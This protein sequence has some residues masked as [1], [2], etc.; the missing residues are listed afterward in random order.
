MKKRIAILICVLCLGLVAAQDKPKVGLVLSGG[1][2]KGFAHIGALKIIEEAGVEVDYVAGTSMGAIVGALYASGYSA[3]AIDSIFTTINFDQLIADELPRSAKTF[4][5][6]EDS[7]RYALSLPFDQ[8]RMSLPSAISKGQNVYNLLVQLLHHVNNV[9]DFNHLPIPFFCIATD[10]ETGKAVKYDK[11][12]LPLVIAASGAFPSLFDPVEIDGKL[13]IDGGVVDNYPVES[14]RQLG[15]EIVIG[16][17][18]QDGLAKREELKTATS[19]L[20][21]INNFR[22]VRAME[23][24]SKLTDIYIQPKVQR[25]SVIDFEEGRT[26]IDYGEKAALRQWKALEDLAKKTAKPKRKKKN[27]VAQNLKIDRLILEGNKNYTRSYIRGKLRFKL[28]D[29]LSFGK[30]QQGISNLIS[31][32]N[33]KTIRYRLQE[34]LGETVLYLDLK[35]NPS[36]TSLR[37]AAHYDNLYKTGVLLNITHKKLLTKDDVFSADFVI[38]DNIRTNIAYY[39]DKGAYWSVGLNSRYTNFSNNVRT[40]LLGNSFQLGNIQVGQLTLDVSDFTNQFY[41]ETVFREEFMLGAGIEHKYL[42]Y[43]TETIQDNNGNKILFEDSNYGSL[44]GFLRLDTYDNKYYPRE[45]VY[46]DGNMHWFF[47]STNFTGDFEPFAV[48]K[49]KIGIAFPLSSHLSW[50]L[51]TQGGFT[52]QGGDL[53]TLDFIMGG[54]GNIKINNEVGFVGYDFMAFSGDSYVQASS[55]LD[56]RFWKRNHLF[57]IANIANIG[58][59]IFED[60]TW[61]GEIRHKGFGVGYGLETFIGPVDILYAWSPDAKENHLYIS[62]GFRF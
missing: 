40:S 22:T 43:A 50:R 47:G 53:G 57:A 29:S 7:E 31:T 28:K 45:G 2:A 51:S 49:A 27:T 6:K 26:I 59:D 41:L 30:F 9:R 19:V 12:Y 44:F 5:E 1:G 60:R 23:A 8:F 24:K 32:N 52:V 37:V 46:F 13:L 3:K 17:D 62:A 33:F 11:G 34:E 21:Q 16:V 14:L 54:Y 36:R 56:Y 4:Y 38:G 25:Y 18:V 10:V 42:S 61:I 20:L 39:I 35:E 55:R 48:A 15:A 58:N